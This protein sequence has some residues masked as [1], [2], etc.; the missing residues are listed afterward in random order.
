MI[1]DKDNEFKELIDF[2]GKNSLRWI[3]LINLIT[4]ETFTEFECKLHRDAFL[5]LDFTID[6]G[7]ILPGKYLHK[8]EKYTVGKLKW[9]WSPLPSKED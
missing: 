2:K 3:K 4:T 5:D 6:R 7:D 9:L 8:V 1:N